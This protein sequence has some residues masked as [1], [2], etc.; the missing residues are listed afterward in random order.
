MLIQETELHEELFRKS[1]PAESSIQTE[2][3]P[4]LGAFSVQV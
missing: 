2:N 4:T 3:A 1:I